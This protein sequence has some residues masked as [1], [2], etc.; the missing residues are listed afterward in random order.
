GWRRVVPACCAALRHPTGLSSEAPAPVAVAAV[1][2]HEHPRP[3]EAAAVQEGIA[4]VPAVGGRQ[5][6]PRV[7]REAAGVGAGHTPELVARVGRVGRRVAVEAAERAQS[8]PR[9]EG[10]GE[11][12]GG[13]HDRVSPE[14]GNRNGSTSIACPYAGFSLQ[15]TLKRT[16]P[17][18]GSQA[19]C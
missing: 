12:N 18:R 8:R 1:A 15:S 6:G 19:R 13:E 11:A 14:K 5:L 17:R 2:L 9:A 7:V 3:P 10:G 4:S 16:S